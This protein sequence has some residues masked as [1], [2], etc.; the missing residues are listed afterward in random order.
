M[1][2]QENLLQRIL[3]LVRVIK[4]PQAQAIDLLTIVLEQ[5]GQVVRM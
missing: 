4:H 1:R 3:G 2:P 5:P